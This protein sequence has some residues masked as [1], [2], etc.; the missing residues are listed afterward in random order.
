MRNIITAN[1]SGGQALATTN[2]GSNILI[3]NY[4]DHSTS[5][6]T[7]WL[8]SASYTITLSDYYHIYI[9]NSFVGESG[10]YYLVLDH[11]DTSAQYHVDYYYNVAKYGTKFV[12]GEKNEKFNLENAISKSQA[13]NTLKTNF[14]AG[15]DTIYSAEV[16]QH[17]SGVPTASTPQALATGVGDIATAK[18][19][20]GKSD[21]ITQGRSDKQT[22]TYGLRAYCTYSQPAL[23]GYLNKYIYRLYNGSTLVGA[24]TVEDSE[25]EL[26]AKS[27]GTEYPLES[28]TLAHSYK[29]IGSQA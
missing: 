4:Q 10:N 14:Q 1:S 28:F 12:Y 29:G 18:Y 23:D 21:G 19:N 5:Y 24:A 26:S 17:V 7:Q 22:N 13:I 11:I 3:V 16:A 15:V 6:D 25:L 2:D 27:V 8:N 9:D 20:S